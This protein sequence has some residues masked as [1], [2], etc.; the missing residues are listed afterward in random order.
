MYLG[1]VGTGGVDPAFG[2]QWL[3]MLVILLQVASMVMGLV[4]GGT[5]QR[6]EVEII[7]GG[8]SKI[9]CEKHRAAEAERMDKLE[10][11]QK[12][13]RRS[14]DDRLQCAVESVSERLRV[15]VGALHERINA[16]SRDMTE[17]TN[18][19]SREVSELNASMKIVLQQ[20]AILNARMDQRAAAVL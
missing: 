17:Q 18:Q 9:E 19:V 2:W 11:I 3:V 12:E 16:V 14:L 4:R 15:D 6:R 13:D 7:E 5:K 10:R 8:M 1:A 20:L